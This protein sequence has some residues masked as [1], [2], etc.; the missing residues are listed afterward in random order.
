MAK[1]HYVTCTAPGPFARCDLALCCPHA[2]R[3][4][5]AARCCSLS[6]WCAPPCCI[7]AS[8]R[9]GLVALF[10]VALNADLF[11]SVGPFLTERLLSEFPWEQHAPQPCP[12]SMNAIKSTPFPIKAGL[13]C[14]PPAV[15]LQPAAPMA[16]NPSPP[17]MAAPASARHS[18]V[19]SSPPRTSHRP[20]SGREFQSSLLHKL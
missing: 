18:T 4:L 15:C 7:R 13:C 11:G 19:I 3:A 10:F 2:R 14:C 17:F 9:R 20:S 6:I 8:L 16:A 12:P 5:R 1:G